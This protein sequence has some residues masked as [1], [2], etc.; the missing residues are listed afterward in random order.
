VGRSGI[1]AHAW[2]LFPNR[3]T[4]PP[5]AVKRLKALKEFSQLGS[6]YQLATRDMEIRGVGNLLGAEQSGQVMTIGYEL[7]MEMLKEAMQEVQGQEIPTVDETKIELKVTAFIPESYISDPEQKL[8]AYRQITMAS[9]K[10]ELVQIAADWS[11]LYGPLPSPAE[12]LL[13]VVELKQIAKPLGFSKIKTDGKQH[14]ILETPMAEPAFKLLLNGLPKNLHSRFVY[15]PKKVTVRGL[16][17]IKPAKQLE[18]LIEWLGTMR[19]A[20]PETEIV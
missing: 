12:Q 5:K 4:L 14:V 16:G 7:Y 18:S 2:L 3:R 17:V 11:D 13:Q 1:Q 9:S 8:A 20:L 6:G 15:G 10:R 19:D